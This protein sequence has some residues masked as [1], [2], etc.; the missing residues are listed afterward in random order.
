MPPHFYTNDRKDNMAIVTGTAY[1]ASVTTPN[2]TYEP[3]YTVNLV[4]DEETAQTFRS[5]GHTVKDM[6][7]GPAL[8]IKRKVN[9][10]NGMIRQPPKLVDSTKNPIDERIGNGSAVKIQY[11]EW[12]SVWKG[13]TFKGLDFQA[14]QVLDLVSVGSVDGGEFDVEDEMEGTI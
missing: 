6:D 9:G 5:Q 2:T 3:V 10:P 8:I 1:W 13:K 4:V 7:E 11:K 12:E 14:M